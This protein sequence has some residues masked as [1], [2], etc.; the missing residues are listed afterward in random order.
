MRADQ[1]TNTEADAAAYAN[2]QGRDHHFG[3]SVFD[4]EAY[5]LGVER[6][7]EWWAEPAWRCVE[8][9]QPH[10]AGSPDQGCVMCGHVGEVIP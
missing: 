2:L 1:H 10:G 8:C 5:A 7:R 4:H 9:D 6:D 3:G